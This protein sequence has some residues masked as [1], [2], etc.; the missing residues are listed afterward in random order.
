M[1]ASLKAMRKLTRESDHIVLIS[2]LGVARAAGL[3]GVRAEHIA[4]DI[5]QKY[6][7]SNDEIISSM[8]LSKRVEIFY[9]YYKEIIL[10]CALQ[11]TSIHEGALR[12]QQAG[13][14]DAIVKRTVYPLYEMAGCDDVIEILG[15]VEKIYCP[16]CG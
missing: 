1:E 9:Q 5:E 10:N 7:Y 4:Y 8:F 14:L 16:N 2:G 3:N 15:N 12:L 6:G 11:P 13:K